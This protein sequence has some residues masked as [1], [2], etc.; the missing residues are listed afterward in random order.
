MAEAPQLSGKSGRF[1]EGP[2]YGARA[3]LADRQHG[4][5]AIWQLRA[6][7]LSGSAVHK[8][9]ANRQLLRIHRGVYAVGRR[10][11][12]RE[13]H[14]MAAVLACG[15]GALLPPRPAAAPQARRRDTRA[16]TDVTVP[17]RRGAR[18][19]EDIEVHV[20]ET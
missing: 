19:R 3:E 5:V 1:L 18:A 7:G 12:T 10:G 6:L 14:L 2:R 16:L 13:A 8:R 20:T 4:V 11:L 15:P 9:A 17:G